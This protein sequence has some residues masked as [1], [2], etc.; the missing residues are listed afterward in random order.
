MKILHSRTCGA[1]AVL[2]ATT[3]TVSPAMAHG[4][5]GYPPPPRHHHHG[6]GGGDLLA[7]LL[8]GGGLVAIASAAS[9]SNSR[10]EPVNVDPG[11]DH[12]SSAYVE[13]GR[14]AYPG[15]PV[16]GEAGYA[17]PYDEERRYEDTR[18]PSGSAGFGAAVDT[19]TAEIEDS[20][21]YDVR[22]VD[23]VDRLNGRI[24]V[25]GR[26]ADGRGFACSVD[27][28]GRVRSVAVDGHAMI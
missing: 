13:S 12:E 27:E 8:I 14:A 26:L 25:E 23:K 22:T 6:G 15:G 20:A 2:A 9:K 4:W 19:C 5:G 21:N 24:A 16:A 28:T 10:D 17:A 18:G 11:E 3:L 7:G 1:L